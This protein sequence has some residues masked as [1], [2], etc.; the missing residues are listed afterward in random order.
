[1]KRAIFLFITFI[2]FSQGFKG[3]AWAQLPNFPWLERDDGV[4][5]VINNKAYCGSGLMVGWSLANDFYCLDLATET[6]TPIA[7]MPVGEERQYACAFT[8]GVDAYV[9]G[10]E[11]GGIDKKDMWMYMPAMNGWMASTAKPG[12]GVRG[13]ACFVIGSGAYIIGGAYSTTN[14]INEVWTYNMSTFGWTQKNNLPFNCWRSSAAS[15]GGKGY[16]LFGR[17]VNGRFRKE[18]HEYDPVAD[19]W[20]LISNFPGAGRAYATMQ[21]INNELVVFG[22]LDT[23]NNY[24]NDIWSYNITSSTWTQLPT[25]PSFG[26]KGGMG[27]TNGSSLYYTCGIDQGNTRLKETWKTNLGVGIKEFEKKEGILIYPNPAS[28]FVQV[29]SKSVLKRETFKIIGMKGEVALEGVLNEDNKI[30]VGTLSQGVY[31]LLMGNSSSR[32]II[33]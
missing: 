6:W 3:Q 2:L 25:M 7:N 32:L 19:S 31:Q 1:M 22:G 29:F 26:R 15:V 9:F 13:A 14:A 30:E 33:E 28:D 20:T 24:Y 8:N 18:L 11:A 12:N 21:N 16:L 23:L 5:F 27:F 10:G 4:A 17:D